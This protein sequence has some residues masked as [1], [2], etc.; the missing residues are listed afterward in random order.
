MSRLARSWSESRVRGQRIPGR[1]RVEADVRG[2]DLEDVIAGEEHAPLR[3]VE[4]DM[5]GGVARHPEH[6]ESVPAKRERLAPGEQPIG[7]D[8]NCSPVGR[9]DGLD[10]RD[11]VLL[12]K[13][14]PC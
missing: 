2:H 8:C 14:V 3:I 4:A 13:A 1:E 7:S 11:D 10:Q 12:G 6:L 9:P 5:S